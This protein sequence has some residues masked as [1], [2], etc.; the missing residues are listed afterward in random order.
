MAE[1]D[2]GI[3]KVKFGRTPAID[4]VRSDQFHNFHGG[5]GDVRNAV[6]AEGNVFVGGGLWHGAALS[7]DV[8][9]L[10]GS[11]LAYPF[12]PDLYPKK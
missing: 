8:R 6:F 12:M 9:L 11:I 7:G 10:D 1:S 2:V 4:Q 3:L 5:S